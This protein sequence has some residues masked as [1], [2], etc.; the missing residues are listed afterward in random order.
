M[1][2]ALEVYDVTY[3]S[4]VQVMRNAYYVL[5]PGELTGHYRYRRDNG[6]H[7]RGLGTSKTT[8]LSSTTYT[9]RGASNVYVRRLAVP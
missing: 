5:P 1:C 6:G 4:N 9:V 2:S 8:S 3:A 7:W